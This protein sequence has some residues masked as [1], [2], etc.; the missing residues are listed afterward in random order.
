MKTILALLLLLPAACASHPSF[1]KGEDGYEA[2]PTPIPE[3]L[4]LRLHL[5]PAVKDTIRADYAARAAGEECAARHFPYFD[6][7]LT[8][9]GNA[10]A[11]C[12][13][14]DN[15]AHFG[16]SFAMIAAASSPPEL[17][18]EDTQLGRFS[19]FHPW[20]VIR[21]VGGREVHDVAELKESVFLA[22]RQGVKRISVLVERSDIPLVLDSPI[23]SDAGKVFGPPQLDELR[24]RSP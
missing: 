11:F 4:D 2:K 18:V 21:K 19:P 10:R 6:V 16:A 14:K 12:Y 1:Q 17:R 7:G 24:A 22:G 20:D 8:R 9:D 3:I 23:S 5:S 15:A 13:P